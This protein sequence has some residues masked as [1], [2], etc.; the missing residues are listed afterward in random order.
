MDKIKFAQL[1]AA[2]VRSGA[3]L[4]VYQIGDFDRMITEGMPQPKPVG[5][6]PLNVDE[7]L[8][9]MAEGQYKIE[10]IKCYRALTGVGLKESKDAV[11]KYWVSK[12][13]SINDGDY[14]YR[15]KNEVEE[16]KQ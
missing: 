5:V 15:R 16:T 13:M 2:I 6:S 10:A 4:D 3:D 8:R 1:I 12:P 9:L 14:D 7:L 11:E